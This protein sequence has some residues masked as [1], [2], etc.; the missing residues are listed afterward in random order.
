MSKL[1][2]VV[3]S[4]AINAAALASLHS[5]SSPDP[6]KG[7]VYITERDNASPAQLAALTGQAGAA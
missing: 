3:L 7:E 1:L 2:A 4:A 6:P 5:I